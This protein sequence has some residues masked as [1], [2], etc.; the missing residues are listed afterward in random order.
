[1][2]PCVIYFGTFDPVILGH[3]DLARRALQLF[4]RLVVA[5]GI[6][7]LRCRVIQSDSG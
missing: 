6:M 1:M 4:D 7:P 2:P 5:V 3:T